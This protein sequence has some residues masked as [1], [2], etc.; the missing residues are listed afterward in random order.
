MKYDA[1]SFVHYLEL[2]LDSATS[3]NLIVHDTKM[4]PY[5]IFKTYSMDPCSIESCKF[6][7]LA[8]LELHSGDT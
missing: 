8:Q 1:I 2:V 6:R 3:H 5:L 7:W 4:M